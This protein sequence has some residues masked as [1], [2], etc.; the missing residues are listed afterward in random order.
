MSRIAL[1]ILASSLVCVSCSRGLRRMP[2]FTSAEEHLNLGNSLVSN[3]KVDEA[4]VHFRKA[5]AIKPDY[6]EAH[7]SLCQRPG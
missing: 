6:P 1:L 3:G 2:D 5:L 4:I 7:F